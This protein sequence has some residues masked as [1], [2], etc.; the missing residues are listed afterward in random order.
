VLRFAEPLAVSGSALAERVRRAIGQEFRGLWT[1]SGQ[2]D[3]L[4][5]LAQAI[6]AK[7]FW[8]EGWISVRQTRIY[9]GGGLPPDNLRR[10]TA[11]E[12]LLRPKELVNK[13]R[14]I[15]INA[16]SGSLDFDEMDDV[17][18]HDYAAAAARSAAVVEGLGRDVGIDEETFTTLLPELAAETGSKVG[19]FARGVALGCDDPGAVWNTMVAQLA[20]SA[21]PSVTFLCGFLA[22]VQECDKALASALLDK[23]LVDTTLAKWFPLLQRSVAIDAKAL[24]RLHRALESGTAPIIQFMNLAWGRTCEDVSGPEFKRLV[25]AIGGKPDGLLVAVEIVSMRFHSDQSAQ[26]QPVPEA[27]EAGKWVLSHYRFHRTNGRATHEDHGLGLI[28]RSSLAD[29]EGASIARRMVRELMAAVARYDAYAHDYGNSVKALFQVHPSDVLDEFFSGDNQSQRNSVRLLNDLLQFRINPM[30]SVTDDVVI[31]W[32]DREPTGRYPVAAAVALLFKRVGDNTPLEWTSLT[33]KLLTRAPE[34]ES[35]F[36]E[37]ERRLYPS[38]YSG[39]FATKLESRLQLLERLD[40]V[41]ATPA[42]AA[43]YNAAKT[44][45]RER[46]ETERRRELEEDRSR[47]GRF[48]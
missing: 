19:E 29:D 7:R 4:E 36:R 14:G 35:V 41:G 28:I 42:L 32:C 23:A 8:R 25:V 5:R 1:S 24:E 9:D 16:N 22:G 45:L 18:N 11:L 3:E 15:V 38:G 2:V 10:L 39:S 47:S 33:P 48:E 43:A 34:P 44:R 30:D 21:T 40:L 6:A 31:A 27:I 37:V 12:E 20:R 17:Q 13:V 46:V 26:R